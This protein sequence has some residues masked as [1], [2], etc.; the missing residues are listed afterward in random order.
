MS[1]SCSLYAPLFFNRLWIERPDCKQVV[2]E[3]AAEFEA[4][5]EDLPSAGGRTH[6][7]IKTRRKKLRARVNVYV[8]KGASID[9][10]F[11]RRTT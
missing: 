2:A 7:Q 5:D 8:D 4:E 6:K 9:I 3:V 10:C 1:N 11:M